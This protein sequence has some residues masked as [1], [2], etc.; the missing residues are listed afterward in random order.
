LRSLLRK[1]LDENAKK[2]S[3]TQQTRKRFYNDIEFF[4]D[5][6]RPDDLPDWIYVSNEEE[7]AK[8]RMKE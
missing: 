7:V 4:Y 6:S 8:E 1:T 5:A 3:I 2:I